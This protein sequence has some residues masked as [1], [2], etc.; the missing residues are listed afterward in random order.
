MYDDV[1]RHAILAWKCTK[2][3][4]SLC[5]D[6][7]NSS[8]NVTHCGGMFQFSMGKNIRLVSGRSRVQSPVGYQV[9]FFFFSGTSLLS[10]S[11]YSLAL[12]F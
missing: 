5:N 6:L 7:S 10:P 9:F 8:A 11:Y 4:V 12:M 3:H 2:V 1:C